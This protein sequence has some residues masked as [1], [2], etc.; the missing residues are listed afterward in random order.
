MENNKKQDI[1]DPVNPICFYG[2]VPAVGVY[3]TRSSAVVDHF[4]VI[5]RR[6]RREKQTRAAFLDELLYRTRQL[7]LLISFF[8]AQQF[9]VEIVVSC[10]PSRNVSIVCLD[11][12]HIG[13]LETIP[14]LTQCLR[15][16]R[17]A[18]DVQILCLLLV[19]VFSAEKDKECC[20]FSPLS[21]L[22][23]LDQ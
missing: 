15:D 8:S 17:Q 10:F 4:S 11:A 12:R 3:R 1:L 9:V 2:W 23:T 13:Y 21:T 22:E 5:C 14:L 19:V 20:W 6:R 18:V 7:F 16:C